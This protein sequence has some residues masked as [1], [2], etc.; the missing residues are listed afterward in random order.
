M[1]IMLI[2][3]KINIYMAKTTRIYKLRLQSILITKFWEVKA[4]LINF[5]SALLLNAWSIFKTEIWKFIFA[6]TLETDLLFV[7]SKIVKNN[8]SQR[9]ISRLIKWYT[10]RKNLL[11]VKFVER[12][13]KDK[14]D[15]TSISIHTLLES[16]M[17]AKFVKGHS[18]KTEILKLIWGFTRANDHSFVKNQDVTKASLPWVI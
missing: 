11:V 5:W 4:L 15:L 1:L 7:I 13:T 9:V 17:S 6:H 12:N 14:E 16:H 8:L 18:Q 2:L 10:P 3:G